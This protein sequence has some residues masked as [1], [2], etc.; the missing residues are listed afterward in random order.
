MAD[1]TNSSRINLVRIAHVFYTHRDIDAVHQFLLDFGFQELKCVGKDVY[2]GGTSSEPFVYC[3]RQGEEDAFGGATFVVESESDL[4]AATKLLPE[5]TEIY[6]LGDAPGGGRGVTFYDP[7]DRFPFHLIHG[8]T[9]HSSEEVL[10]QLRLNFPT[11]KH[12][13]GNQSQRFQ[14]VHK[15]G[16]FGMCVTD[17]ARSLEFYTTHF[18]F[19]PSDVLGH[20]WL[21]S[22]GYESCWGVGRHIMGSQIFDYWFDPSRFIIEHYVDGDLVD[23][24]LPTNRSLASPNNLHIWGPDLPPTFLQ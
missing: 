6:D 10:P 4:I 23:D 15:L 2:Y 21:R 3:A 8:Q 22:K 20:D 19:K 5:S 14:K 13:A 1:S 7:I 18:N 17:F 9:P 12:R 11:D 24:Q 16:H